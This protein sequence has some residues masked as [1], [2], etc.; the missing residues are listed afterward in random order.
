[1][2]KTRRVDFGMGIGF[3]ALAVF[4]FMSA[5]QMLK[6]DKGIGPGDY[7]KVI[8]AGLFILGAILS[9]DSFLRGFPKI[10]V[11]FSWKPVA[12]TAV[13]IA[14][15]IVYVQLMRL[16][17]FI[18]LTPFYLFFAIYYFGYRKWRTMI[19]VG[20]LVTAGIHLVF[21][22]IFLVMLPVFRLF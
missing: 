16:L 10:E 4:V 15:T 12:R 11:K 19:L 1:M 22:E 20:I 6:V 18:F 17:G 8:A 5:N 9:I 13:F 21:R 7:P 3:M 14:V 2:K